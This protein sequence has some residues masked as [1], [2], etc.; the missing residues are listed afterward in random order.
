MH[1]L[2]HQICMITPRTWNVWQRTFD[3]VE[4]P[5][6]DPDLLPVSSLLPFCWQKADRPHS[7]NYPHTPPDYR[8]IDITLGLVMTTLNPKFEGNFLLLHLASQPLNFDLLTSMPM[9]WPW[10][11][12]WILTP[13]YDLDLKQCKRQLTLSGAITPYGYFHTPYLPP[14]Y[15]PRCKRYADF[16]H[17]PQE[18]N[19]LWQS[20]TTKLKMKNLPLTNISSNQ[21]LF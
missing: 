16:I 3:F 6:K 1:H 11:W 14:C 17:Q 2:H 8:H 20:R 15:C 12:P 13:T 4:A 21:Y 9:F 18:S 19:H 5:L 7:R 10:P